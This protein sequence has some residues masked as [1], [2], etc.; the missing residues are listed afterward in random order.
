ML[1]ILIC[2]AMTL[3]IIYVDRAVMPKIDPYTILAI[4]VIWLVGALW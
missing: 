4:A 1:T 2:L 3:G